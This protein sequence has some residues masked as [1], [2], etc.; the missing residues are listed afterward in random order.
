MRLQ[1]L[2]K[3]RT[4][5]LLGC[6]VGV[7]VTAS[8]MVP[9]VWWADV[10][11]PLAPT[12]RNRPVVRTDVAE[13][14]RLLGYLD[15]EVARR[16]GYIYVLGSSASFSDQA[17]AFANLSLGTDFVSTGLILQGAHVDRRDGF[18][19]SLLDSQYVVV[20]NPPQVHLGEAHQ[21]VVVIPTQSFIDGGNVAR[22]F[23]KMPA[24][25]Q[26]DNGVSVSVYARVRPILDDEIAELSDRLRSKYPDRPDIYEP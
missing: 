4:V 8:V 5:G 2:L 23:A 9:G 6:V 19:R 24:E 18:P 13:V 17:L 1:P 14:E 7:L 15:A 3:R 26:L 12:V 16:P 22:A 20:A 11:G 10:L 21:Q 25:F